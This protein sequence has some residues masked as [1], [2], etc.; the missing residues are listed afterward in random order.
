MNLVSQEAVTMHLQLLL[1]DLKCIT[2]TCHRCK[3]VD[4]ISKLKQCH[5]ESGFYFCKKCQKDGIPLCDEVCEE[6]T[7]YQDDDDYSEEES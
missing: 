6:I 7:L 3:W 5:N 1:Y 4:E 2:K